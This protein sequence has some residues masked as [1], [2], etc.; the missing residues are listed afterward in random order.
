[1]F[2]LRNKKTIILL[3]TLN[4]RPVSIVRGVSCID[5]SLIYIFVS[6]IEKNADCFALFCASTFPNSHKGAQKTPLFTIKSSFSLTTGSVGADLLLLL[7]P[8]WEFVIVLCIVVC[9]FMFILVLQSS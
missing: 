2:W 7:L 4:Q 8:L 3:R 6:F 1:M 5:P 9:Y